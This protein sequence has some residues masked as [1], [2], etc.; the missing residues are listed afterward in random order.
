[1]GYRGGS[2]AISLATHSLAWAG[3]RATR[4]CDLELRPG[5]DVEVDM[6]LE[7]SRSQIFFS[8]NTTNPTLLAT[9]A[10]LDLEIWSVRQGTLSTI[11]IHNCYAEGFPL[12]SFS[13]DGAQ[14]VVNDVRGF[15][16]MWNTA[17]GS[18]S[19]QIDKRAHGRLL[20]F[21][22]DSRLVAIAYG[23]VVHLWDVATQNT[24]EIIS[25]KADRAVFSHDGQRLV[26]VDNGHVEYWA[27]SPLE[28]LR[29][30]DFDYTP[31]TDKFASEIILIIFSPDDKSL[32]LAANKSV[33]IWS[34]SDTECRYQIPWIYEGFR[35][36]LSQSLALSPDGNLVGATIDNHV[37]IW[38]RNHPATEPPLHLEMSHKTRTCRFEAEST[39]LLVDGGAVVIP[40]QSASRGARKWTDEAHE[41]LHYKGYGLSE[42]RKWITKDNKRLL[43]LPREFRPEHHLE[44]TYDDEVVFMNSMVAIIAEPGHLHVLKFRNEPGMEDMRWVK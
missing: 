38:H 20:C 15:L 31:P 36:V 21:S 26:V 16:Q 28:R 44:S 39:R 32:A 37:W 9:R 3:N 17:T 11:P 24:T 7:R 25:Q 19:L 14:L 10:P 5:A 43:Y 40:T 22:P 18:L 35:N 41:L 4:I 34:V 33:F 30:W 29:K 2:Y 12:L 8:A 6:P 23:I 42:D 13:P 27:L 1:M